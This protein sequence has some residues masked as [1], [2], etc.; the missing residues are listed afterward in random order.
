MKEEFVGKMWGMT[1]MKVKVSEE[2][3][4]MRGWNSLTTK[5]K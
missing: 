2:K 3:K 1:Q 5:R 4:G